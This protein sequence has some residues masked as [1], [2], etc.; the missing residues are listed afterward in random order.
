MSERREQYRVEPERPFLRVEVVGFRGEKTSGRAVDLALG[1]VGVLFEPG[2]DPQLT[3]GTEIEASLTTLVLLQPLRVAVGVR[4]REVLDEG[5]RYGLEFVDPKEVQQRLPYVLVAEF[6]RR[7]S[8]RWQPARTIAVELSPA[9]GGASESGT[10]VDLSGGGVAVDVPPERLADLVA[11]G[12]LRVGFHLPGRGE[13]LSLRARLLAWH[14]TRDR[15]VLNLQFD[16][17][18]D[19]ETARCASTIEAY[20]ESQLPLKGGQPT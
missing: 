7:S 5:V 16:P 1:G 12:R 2:T 19:D 14:V 8:P 4:R 6:N 15:A 11:W 9:R 20:V 10:L 13:R 18:G 3:V 17:D